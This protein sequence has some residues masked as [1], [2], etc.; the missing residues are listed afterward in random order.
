MQTAQI[1]QKLKELKPKLSSVYPIHSMAI[2]GSFARNEQTADS[3]LDL[4]VDV[5]SSIGLRFIDLGNELEKA[6]G[7]KVDLVSKRGVKEAYLKAIHPDLI[8][9]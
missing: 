3:D 2:F 7:L 1:Y 9:V 4:L 8:Y 6:L 5:D